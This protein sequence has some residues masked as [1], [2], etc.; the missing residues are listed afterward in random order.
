MKTLLKF[1]FG[2]AFGFALVSQAF[3]FVA[4]DN[5][6]PS[7]VPVGTYDTSIRISNYWSA[8]DVLMIGNSN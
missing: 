7:T 1:A 3:A 5:Y 4:Y 2:F 8:H 6:V